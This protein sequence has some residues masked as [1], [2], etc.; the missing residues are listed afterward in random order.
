MKARILVAAL[1]A[2]TSLMAQGP[3]RSFGDR[4]N[5]TPPTPAEIAQMEVNHLTKFFSLT[6]TQ[7]T[8]VT[9][10]VTAEQTCLATNSANLKTARA[11]LLGAIKSGPGGVVSA[12][13]AISPLEA[14]QE[15]CRATAAAS[16]YVQL[17]ST[18]QMQLGNG[19]GPLM[20][21]GP[22]GPADSAGTAG[23]KADFSLVSKA[24]GLA[25]CAPFH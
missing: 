19:L 8:A 15:I 24:R 7:V 10:F 2:A 25:G 17:T 4:A 22:G 12:V 9:G 23:V 20:G 5:A 21:G 14:D 11:A 3:G 13:N 18:Q 6:P 1:V 16:I